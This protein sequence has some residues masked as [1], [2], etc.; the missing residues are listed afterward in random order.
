MPQH[1][2]LAFDGDGN[3]IMVPEE[4]RS[5]RVRRGGGRR[6]RPR[7]VFDPETGRQLEIPITATFDDLIDLDFEADR[8]RLEAVDEAGH[9]LP[10]VPAAVVEIRETVEES[11]AR[12]KVVGVGF[13]RPHGAARRAARRRQLPLH[14]RDGFGVRASPARSAAAS[15]EDHCRTRAGGRACERRFADDGAGRHHADGARSV[16]A[17]ADDDAVCGS[18]WHC[19]STECASPIRDGRRWIMILDPLDDEQCLGQLTTIARELSGTTLVRLVA[20]H[21]VEG[22]PDLS[23]HEAVARWLQSKPQADDDGKESTRYIVCDV[24][25]RVRLFAD[26]PNCVERATDALMLLEA[27]EEMK[28]LPAMPRALV[29]IDKPQRHTGLVEKRGAHWYAVDLFPRRNSARNFSWGDFGKDA[30]QGVH[31]YIGKPVLGYFG[32]SSVGDS[33]GN[34]E[35]GWIGRGKKNEKKEQ[36][37]TQPAPGAKPAPDARKAT[38]SSGGSG[39]TLSAL[40][41]IGKGAISSSGSGNATKGGNDGGKKE[42]KDGRAAGSASSGAGG[43]AGLFAGSG[44]RARAEG[45]GEAKA[46]ARN[47]DHQDDAGARPQRGWWGVE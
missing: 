42:T 7:H 39:G 19:S 43:L 33:L 14:G 10:D 15:A 44:D 4:A 46:P 21:I 40:V 16:G 30:L 1:Y 12:Q 17:G 18:W 45:G 47:G 6:G 28:L 37:S 11:E 9:I 13:A 38:S 32:L 35:D 20:R 41:A 5:W 2:P 8:Y 23:P 22:A 3:P 34:A 27:L 24:P 25:Q 36:P 26:D 29:T 31:K